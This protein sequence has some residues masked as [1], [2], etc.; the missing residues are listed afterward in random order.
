[1]YSVPFLL[2][3]SH[4]AIQTSAP[5]ASRALAHVVVYATDLISRA[6]PVSR[7]AL[8]NLA[9]G[10]GDFKYLPCA[11]MHT[12]VRTH[13]HVCVCVVSLGLSRAQEKVHR[14]RRKPDDRLL[15]S[16]KSRDP[17]I[18][19]EACVLC[20]RRTKTRANKSGTSQEGHESAA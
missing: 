13:A 3:V 6:Q 10:H 14:S 1:M 2:L 5:V 19:I 11:L 7:L 16:R 8:R 17:S 4:T 18:R 15:P 9:V 20:E 12:H